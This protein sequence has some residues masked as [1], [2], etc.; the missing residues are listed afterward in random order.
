VNLT[1][2]FIGLAAT[3]VVGLTLC[4]PEASGSYGAAPSCGASA[5]VR[6]STIHHAGLPDDAEAIGEDD[7]AATAEAVQ[8]PPR[9]GATDEDGRGYRTS[10]LRFHYVHGLVELPSPDRIRE[11][12]VDLGVVAN[13]Y[14]AP[15]DGVPT[16]SVVLGEVGSD[17]T[18]QYVY[19]SAANHIASEVRNRIEAH[20]GGAAVFVALHDQDVDPAT[21]RDIRRSRQHRLRFMIEYTGPTRLVDGFELMYLRPELHGQPSIE[22]LLRVEVPLVPTDEHGYVAWRPGVTPVRVTIGEL[23]E[24]PTQRFADSGLQQVLIA[25]RDALTD[26][27]LMAVRTVTNPRVQ[28][29]ASEIDGEPQVFPITIVTGVVSEIRTLASGDRIKDPAERLNHRHHRR[30]LRD[31]P[32]Q[33]GV[34]GRQLLNRDELDNY[35]F[36]LGRHPGRRV[37]VAVA[38]GELER[39]EEGRTVPTISLDYIVTENKP[40]LL[41]VQGSNTGTRNT[42][43]WRQR[44][45][46]FHNQV[47]N[48]DDILNVDYS[49]ANFSDTHTVTG[50]YEARFFGLDRVRWRVHGMWNDFD[51]SDVGFAALRFTGESWSV[52][53]ELAFNIYQDRQFFLDVVAGARYLNVEVRN[54]FFQI[55]ITEADEDFLIPYGGIRMEKITE[56]DIFRAS[57]MFEGNVADATNVDG[58]QMSG[59]GRLFPDRDWLLLRWDTGYSFFLEP[60]FNRAAWEDVTTP[61]TSTLAHEIALGARG[62]YAFGNRLIPQ[63]SM[64]AGGMFTVRGYPESVVAGDTVTIGTAEY[65]FHL[66]R[67]FAPQEEAADLFG[68]PFRVAPQQ[69]YGRADWDLTFRAF[70]DAAYVHSHRR[71]AFENNE[72]LIGAGVGVE[73]QLLRNLNVRLDWGFALKRLDDRVSSGSNR[74]HFAGTLLF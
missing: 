27:G 55:P 56:R 33:P 12:T 18:L 44:F 10:E 31:S 35:I 62:Q 36:R 32:V 51:A 11:W 21:G 49:T 6:L 9:P 72:T 19:A 15:R 57:V 23:N 63:I 60:L 17:R 40:L 53:G 4:V 46:L 13:G 8:E 5:A 68:Q 41:Y 71:L 22:T 7:E 61:E 24:L 43:R 38:P 1:T 39:D 37:D 65:R 54:F 2:H 3:T 14:V 30:I 73:L 34:P 28:Q 47:T 67:A 58:T 50:S 74:L 70:V 69:L 42:G 25:V 20:I 52:G 66:P 29:A 64:V 59:L 26:R 16:Q 45:G 48:N